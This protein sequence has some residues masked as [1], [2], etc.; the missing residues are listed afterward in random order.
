MSMTAS[1]ISGADLVRNLDLL[2]LIVALPLFIALDWPIAG[3]L[4][5]GGAWL[6]GMVGKA[7]AD[8]RRNQALLAA[9]RN[10][11]LGLTAATM[12]GRLWI[13]AAAI[14]VVGLAVDREAGLAGA[15]L[16]AA[17][18]TAHL[19][20]EGIAQLMEGEGESA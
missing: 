2:V 5:A 4:A 17:L 15:V 9:N 20:G 1:R 19:A 8:R 6:I 12:L 10:T 16:A 11:A 14:L 18:V 7:F 13:L 3:Y